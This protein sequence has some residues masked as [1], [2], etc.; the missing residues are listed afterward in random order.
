[1]PNLVHSLDATSL[2]LL[3]DLMKDF[4]ILNFFSI[5]D[6]FAVTANNAE[7]LSD[8]LKIVYSTIYSEDN[9]LKKLDDNILLNLK[10]HLGD[11][12]DEKT[13]YVI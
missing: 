12:F 2:A 8:Y 6:C 7:K 1:M 11:N 13:L 4:N 10:L 3:V 5:H 9:Y